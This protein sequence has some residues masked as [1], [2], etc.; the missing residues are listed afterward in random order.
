VVVNEDHEQD[1]ERCLVVADVEVNRVQATVAPSIPDQV[2]HTEIRR[3]RAGTIR[4]IEAKG[5]GYIHDELL[6]ESVDALL[7]FGGEGEGVQVCPLGVR[8][9]EVEG[10]REILG[11]R[12]PGPGGE[13]LRLSPGVG[14][15]RRTD[16][17]RIDGSRGLGRP[18][19]GV[20]QKVAV[21]LELLLQ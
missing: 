18:R 3:P 7:R 19:Q 2:L 11:N 9:L 12:S 1:A 13:T 4:R 5:I 14:F 10:Q 21:N 16:P 15:L 6:N 8:N 17:R 20:G